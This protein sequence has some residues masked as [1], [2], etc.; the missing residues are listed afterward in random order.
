MTLTEGALDTGR[1]GESVIRP[2]Q[3]PGRRV[4]LGP[5]PGLPLFH[6]AQAGR[7]DGNCPVGNR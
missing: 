6:S 1:A 3:G 4:A 7:G 2:S 5:L